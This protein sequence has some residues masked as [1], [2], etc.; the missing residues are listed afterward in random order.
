MFARFAHLRHEISHTAV[1]LDLEVLH[2]RVPLKQGLLSI[3]THKKF[4]D[5]SLLL[6]LQTFLKY[7]VWQCKQRVFGAVGYFV[8]RVDE[9]EPV[10]Q[11]EG[12]QLTRVFLV[13]PRRFG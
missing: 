1:I 3:L 12:L 10:V 13:L 2:H 6:R 8:G 9:S 4:P 5:Q 11:F 7:W